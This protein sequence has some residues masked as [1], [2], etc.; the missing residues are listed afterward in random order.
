MSNLPTPNDRVEDLLYA[1]ATGDDTKSSYSQD[2][3]RKV[4]DVYP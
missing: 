1:I 4:I 3:G 2:E